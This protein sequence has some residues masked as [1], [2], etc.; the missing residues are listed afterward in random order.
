MFLFASYW[1][2]ANKNITCKCP[3]LLHRSPI[4][5]KS[6][7]L[8]LSPT[9]FASGVH[10]H[11]LQEFRTSC[12]NSCL[13]FRCSVAEYT[14][15]W[16]VGTLSYTIPRMN[17]QDEK[18]NGATER[19]QRSHYFSLWKLFSILSCFLNIQTLPNFTKFMLYVLKQIIRDLKI[20]DAATVT[21]R[22]QHK[23]ILQ[24]KLKQKVWIICGFRGFLSSVGLYKTTSCRRPDNTEF[25]VTA[26]RD[27]MAFFYFKFKKDIAWFWP[28]YIASV[29]R[30]IDKDSDS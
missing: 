16:R 10:A 11:I 9:V 15:M 7:V 1:I 5:F 2:E 24:A 12:K 20:D 13:E 19:W 18:R 25:H 26:C 21:T 28:D 14:I 17:P 23:A 4:A 30:S 22:L 27:V 3:S 29:F 8:A 6:S